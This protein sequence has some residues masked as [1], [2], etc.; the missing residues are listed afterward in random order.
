MPKRPTRDDRPP[1]PFKP[2]LKTESQY[3]DDLLRFFAFHRV[4]TPYVMQQ[5]FPGPFKYHKTTMSHLNWLTN[6]GWLRRHEYGQ[7]TIFNITN[8]GNRRARDIPGIDLSF[9]PYTYEEPGGKH[10]DHDLLITKIAVSICQ[11]IQRQQTAKFLEDG[12]YLLD[13]YEWRDTQHDESVFP[14]EDRKPDYWYMFKDSKG[15]MIRF[16]EVVAG[17]RSP[18]KLKE[19][20]EL[21][22]TWGNRPEIQ[23]WLKAMYAK[24][25][26]TNPVPEYQIHFILSSDDWRYTE[27]WKERQ[28]QQQGFQVQPVTQ[29][30]L[31]TITNREIINALGEG[32]SIANA[33]WRRGYDL[34]KHR[35]SWEGAASGERTRKVD[36]LMQTATT[37]Q[38]FA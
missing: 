15:W 14:F 24:H 30:R 25:G 27:D 12:R 35:S 38:L 10:F 32:R 33:R 19:K 7:G 9:I 16:V 37:Y 29:A 23:R 3:D 20:L 26:A 17:E 13:H 18:T 21:Y 11:S 1:F 22:E 4:A 31:W 36:M 6:N 5:A 28:T 8:T 2:T 34:V